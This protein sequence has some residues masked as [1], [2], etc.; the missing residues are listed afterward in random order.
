MVFQLVSRRYEKG[1][2]ILSRNKSFS[3]GARSSP[4]TSW[5][6]QSSTGY[7]TTAT[8]SPSTDRPTASKTACR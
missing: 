7:C 8:S 4:T 1:S 3:D 2:I 5:P 6:P